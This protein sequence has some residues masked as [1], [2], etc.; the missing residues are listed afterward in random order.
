MNELVDLLISSDRINYKNEEFVIMKPSFDKL[1]LIC[2]HNSRDKR[3]GRAGPQVTIR[4]YLKYINNNYN[5]LLFTYID[6]RRIE[7]SVDK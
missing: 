4:Y 7:Q 2:C 3:C 1:I 5:N 6:I